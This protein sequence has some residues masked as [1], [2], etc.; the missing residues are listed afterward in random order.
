MAERL[1]HLERVD[2]YSQ[3]LTKAIQEL[4]TALEHYR[5]GE[6]LRLPPSC[7]MFPEINRL[8]LVLGFKDK[9]DVANPISSLNMGRPAFFAQQ[10]GARLRSGAVSGQQNAGQPSQPL[11]WL[12]LPTEGPFTPMPGM[13]GPLRQEVSGKSSRDNGDG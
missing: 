11:P 5:A 8:L 3:Q 9:T 4:G 7:R 1:A 6:P 13:S 2:D 12:P 10:S